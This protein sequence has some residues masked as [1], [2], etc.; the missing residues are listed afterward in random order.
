MS[1]DFLLAISVTLAF[2]GGVI[3]CG[4]I[5]GFFPVLVGL[6]YLLLVCVTHVWRVRQERARSARREESEQDGPKTG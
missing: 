2:V 6:S 3:S 1:E 5:G 4:Q